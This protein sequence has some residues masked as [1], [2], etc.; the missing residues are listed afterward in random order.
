MAAVQGV[1]EESKEQLDGVTPPSKD[2]GKDIILVCNVADG[3]ESCIIELKHWRTGKRVGKQ[4]VSDFM[5]VIVAEKRSGGVFL[6]TSGFAA[7]AFE[8][9]TEV[10]RSRL[11]FGGREKIVLLAKTYIR[12]CSGLWSPPTA[13]PEVLFDGTD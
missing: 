10:S 4:T 5:H 11:W 3:D 7:D 8:G 2:G 1:L 12:A 6:S 13:L 9:I